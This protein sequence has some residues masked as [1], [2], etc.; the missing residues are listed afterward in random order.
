MVCVCVCVCVRACMR[1]CVRACMRACVCVCACLRI[2]KLL[3]KYSITENAWHFSHHKIVNNYRQTTCI[4]SR[5][6]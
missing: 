5:S 3:N 4:L 2:C 1:E 6:H